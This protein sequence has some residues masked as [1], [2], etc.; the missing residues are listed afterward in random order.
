M[1][2]ILRVFFRPPL[3]VARLGGSP[4]PLENF[5]WRDDPTIH[6]GA[7]NTI[8]PAVS[9]Q[10]TVDGSLVPYLPSILQFRDG[11]HLRPVA[12][13]LELWAEVEYTVDDPEVGLPSGN[14]AKVTPA[15]GDRA[16]MALTSTLLRTAGGSLDG[17]LYTVHVANKKAVR[18]TGNPANGF[19][20]W[21]QVRADDYDSHQLLAITP[22][23]P[24]Q[25]PLVPPDHPIPLGW[26]QAIRPL[27]RLHTGVNLDVL[28]VRF[29]PA[30]GEVY[31]PPAAVM[32]QDVS[33]GRF[34]QI[35]P[36]E[37][38][39][40]NAK[41]SWTRYDGSYATYLNPE[42][43]DTYDGADQP[44]NISWGVVDDTC[45]GTIQAEVVAQGQRF[46]AVA[47]VSAGPPHFAPDR[48]PFL[49]LADD[50]AD[51]DLEP[52]ELE[53][54]RQNEADTQDR[55]ADLFQRAYETA[56]LISLDGTRM[57]GLNDNAGSGLASPKMGDL[58]YTDQRSMT[59]EDRPYA[60]AIVDDLIGKASSDAAAASTRVPLLYSDLVPIAHAQLAQQDELLDFLLN[61]AARVRLMVRPP[62][63]AFASLSPKVAND[64][65]PDPNF[66]DP[67]IDRDQAHDMRMPPY[68]RD[69]MGSALG[70]TRRQY[71]ELMR[72]VEYL[73][74][75][76][77][78]IPEGVLA[79]A[80]R[81]VMASSSVL[82]NMPLRQRIQRTLQRIREY[83]QAAPPRAKP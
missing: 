70:L 68:M 46:V 54:L 55:L 69:E 31:G 9:L 15:A 78:E 83:Q 7:Q 44:P 67:R 74:E 38:R 64:A 10:V 29:T 21:H 61:Q 30:R 6:G 65:Q 82:P 8:E 24:A 3:V 71:V 27:A 62:Y 47:R 18:R 13:F 4:N 19:E 42:P 11:E 77:K 73:A 59:S 81:A 57:R 33:T 22:P 35:V 17:V 43:W 80:A 25:E 56:N 66:R 16:E 45:D 52:A 48:R 51:R 39:V 63:G 36:P 50:L 20:A 2:R 34:F 41:A 5:V 53:E 72:Y 79:R 37:N 32:G 28:R 60:D 49:T 12:P 40:L 14:P 76:R 23:A 1:A 58:P 26:F 75:S